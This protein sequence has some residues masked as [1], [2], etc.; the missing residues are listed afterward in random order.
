MRYQ[1]SKVTTMRKS[2]TLVTRKK[3]EKGVGSRIK[4]D[5]VWFQIQLKNGGSPRKDYN[6]PGDPF[7][8]RSN[9]KRVAG[10]MAL[11]I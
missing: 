11:F 5:T 10:G 7:R 3:S 2:H 4:S 1:Y 8:G 9:G 6:H